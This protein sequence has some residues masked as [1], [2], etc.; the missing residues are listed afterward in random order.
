VAQL[1]GLHA[2]TEAVA[3]DSARVEAQD[4]YAAFQRAVDEADPRVATIYQGITQGERDRATL[5]TL[6]AI[7]SGKQDRFAR[8]VVSEHGGA[9]HLAERR[10][11]PDVWSWLIEAG[12]VRAC[13]S[14]GPDTYAFVEPM[15]QHYVL[16]REAI[17]YGVP[18]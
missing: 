4:L 8:F 7:A 17:E 5:E 18:A 13:R 10:L 6:R 9:F 12:T 1:L 11:D 3:R 15:L 16:M 2:G 14:V